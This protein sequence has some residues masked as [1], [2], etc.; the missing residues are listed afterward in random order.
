[1]VHWWKRGKSWFEESSK[2]ICHQLQK[3]PIFHIGRQY[4]ADDIEHNLAK[5]S[6]GE[7]IKGFAYNSPKNIWE[8]R[9]FSTTSFT[10]AFLWLQK[11]IHGMPLLIKRWDLKQ[12]LQFFSVRSF[13]DSSTKLWLKFSNEDFSEKLMHYLSFSV[14]TVPHS[15]AYHR[16]RKQI[17]Q[18]VREWVLMQVTIASELFAWI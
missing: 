15:D 1:M 4:L 6:V 2:F 18:S 11:H 9:F 5:W 3:W 14:F 12:K 17:K 7:L 8:P 10:L 13:S 16:N